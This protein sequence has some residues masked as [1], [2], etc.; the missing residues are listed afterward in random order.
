MIGLQI[1]SYTIE[2]LIGEG[3]M[4]NVYLGRHNHIGR[5]VAIKAL[6]PNL[7]KNPELKERFKNEA[8][9]LSQLHHPNIV[10][11]YDYVETDQGI[12]L[13]MEYAEGMPL[14]KY[15]DEV[16]GPIPDAKLIPLFNQILDGVNYAH[17]RNVV[18]R[19]IKPSN[20]IIT[21]EGNA[22]IL[23]FGIAKIISD[24]NHKLT[25]TGTKLG[26][27]LYM[28]PEQVKGSPVDFRTDIYS[29]GITLFQCVT[30]KCPYNDQYSEYEV[31]K[32][33]VEFP[34]PDAK[35][36]Y[37]GTSALMEKI[38]GI[39]TQKD[40]EKRYQNCI[41]FKNDLNSDAPNITQ[42]P[43]ETPVKT[44]D[45]KAHSSEIKNKK[46]FYK[47]KKGA[48]I[49]WNI[50]FI[51]LF[52][53]A[54]VATIFKLSYQKGEMYVLANN[55]WLR[56]G[57]NISTQKNRISLLK[58]G[59]KI[60][61]IS[62]DNNADSG[63]TVW[64]EIVTD[65]NKKGFVPLEFLGTESEW[66]NL[67]KI[68]TP[69]AIAEIPVK[70]KK[71]AIRYFS[72]NGLLNTGNEK[73]YSMMNA[74]AQGYKPYTLMDFNNDQQDDFSMVAANT[75]KNDFV[76]I[77]FFDKNKQGPEAAFNHTS[78]DML[79]IK[80][81]LKGSKIFSGNYSESI[82]IDDEGNLVPEKTKLYNATQ[83]NNLMVTG[84]KSGK[85]FYLSFEPSLNE[86]IKTDAP[87]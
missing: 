86:I 66:K 9:T 84:K 34:L 37:P 23:D 70:F 6:N 56:S 43:A 11:L 62:V 60:T 18:H 28:S 8:S 44:I 52:L 1:L 85:T 74:Q 77:I 51:S 54:F 46:T 3:G 55:L 36:L 19:D 39:A 59:E 69:Q 7:A 10:A 31:Y 42:P 50:F 61:V 79:L 24:T 53:G 2:K 78:G 72:S 73:N 83:R 27:V 15:I 13:V 67:D 65:D 41:S 47:R 16:S 75:E 80:K 12:F 30:G 14:D 5:K 20:I 76:L 40:P 68:F 71:A 38:I 58:N 35:S 64:A 48:V 25:K 17:E 26:T 22:K 32:Q 21:P 57:K 4:G 49:F 82:S 81:V 63:E 33:I 29:L 45:T 87:Q